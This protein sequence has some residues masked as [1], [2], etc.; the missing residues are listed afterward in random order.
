MAFV[1]TYS[2]PSM[3]GIE[4][5]FSSCQ[6]FSKFLGSQVCISNNAG[7]MVLN[8]F[9]LSLPQT[10]KTS[11]HQYAEIKLN[12]Y[13]GLPHI[14]VVKNLPSSFMASTKFFPLSDQLFSDLVL[15]R[16]CLR[17]ATSER[18]FTKLSLCW[19][20]RLTTNLQM[21]QWPVY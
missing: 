14:H 1:R 18:C 11:R 7:E 3:Y 16:T 5:C 8:G 15:K 19:Q 20:H 13:F 6:N 10:T 21:F 2:K 17:A 9:Y 12:V 4:N